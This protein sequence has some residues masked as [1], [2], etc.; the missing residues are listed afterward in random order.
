MPKAVSAKRY[1]Q[2]VFEIALEGGELDGWLDDLM[3]L[4][5]VAEN[6]EFSGIL[7]A[8]QV[9]ASRKMSV[10]RDVLGESVGPLALNLISLLAARNLAHTV[11]GVA[12]QYQQLLDAH[13]GIERAEVVSAVPLDDAQQQRVQDLLEGMIGNEIRLTS[14]V[15]PEILGGLVIR[16]GDRVLDG[17]TRTKLNAMRRGLVEQR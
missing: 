2:A 10:I 9:S 16:V 17:S 6:P 4:A 14:R 11:P 3:L 8:A 1:A 13:R 7:D 15:E 12:S 5:Q